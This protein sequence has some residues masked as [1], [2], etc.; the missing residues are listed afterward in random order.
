[1]VGKVVYLGSYFLRKA[2]MAVNFPF[3]IVFAYT[4]FVGC[5]FIIICLKVILNIFSDFIVDPLVF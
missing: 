1:M 5:V 2:Y 4:A 3:R